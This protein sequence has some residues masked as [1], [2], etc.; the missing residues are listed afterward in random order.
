RPPLPLLPR[1]RRALL[2]PARARLGDPLRAR[3]RGRAPALQPARAARR[4]A[5]RRQSPFAEEPLPAARLPPDRAQPGP[6]PAAHSRPRSR[7]A[8]L[9]VAAG[10]IVAR[11]LRLAAAPPRRAAG[12]AADH[13]APPHASGGRAGCLVRAPGSAAV[14]GPAVALIGSRGIP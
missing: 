13:P 2:P 5:S 4:D 1:G 3:R 11:R 10:A 12:P 6:H 9:G 8:R 7:S 14:S